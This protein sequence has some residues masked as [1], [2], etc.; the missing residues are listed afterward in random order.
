MPLDAAFQGEGIPGV[1]ALSGV[2][3]DKIPAVVG[4]GGGQA[5]AQPFR[6]SSEKGRGDFPG[7]VRSRFRRCFHAGPVKGGEAFQ[8]DDAEARIAAEQ[9]ALRPPEHLDA[10]EVQEVEVVGVLVEEGDVVQVHAHH[11]LVDPGTESPEIEA[12]SDVGAVPGLEEVGRHGGEV[13]DG[14]DAV[15]FQPPHRH[16]RDGNG[17][18]EERSRKFQGGRDFRGLQRVAHFAFRL[19]GKGQ[20]EGGYKGQDHG[21][22]GSPF[23]LARQLL[24]VIGQILSMS[25]SPARTA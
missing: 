23:P 14:T 19:M 20:Q 12:G 10:A 24:F 11:R 22:K 3:V 9:H 8:P 1:T 6:R 7:S 18:L 25:T 13:P 21:R 2:G 17:L 4:E 16:L 15:L 5:P